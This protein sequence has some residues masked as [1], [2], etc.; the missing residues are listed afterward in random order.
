[1]AKT[2]SFCFADDLHTDAS[3][4]RHCGSWLIAAPPEQSAVDTLRKELRDEHTAYRGYLENLLA[5]LK[6]VAVIIVGLAVAVTGYFGWQ[7]ST[8]I[9]ASAARIEHD[10]QLQM[11]AAAKAATENAQLAMQE[12]LNSAETQAQIDAAIQQELAGLQTKVA[13]E[14]AASRTEFDATMAAVSALKASAQA[15]REAFA[16]ARGQTLADSPSLLPLQRVRAGDK[17]GL[18]RLEDMRAHRVEALTFVLGDFYEGP[19]IW[20]YFDTLLGTAHF[21]HVVL[22]EPDGRVFGLVEA[23]ALATQ[24]NPPEQ[25]LL[26]AE[27]GADP[28]GQPDEAAV[29]GWNAFATDLTNG[30][31]ERLVSLPMFVSGDDA[32]PLDASSVAALETM[33]VLAVDRL[34]VV[35][36]DRRFA[37]IVER[38]RLTTRVL[39]EIAPTGT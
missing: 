7:T 24:L 6:S 25:A 23:A 21:R 15:I 11:A 27:Y 8:N 17:E 12:R 22:L 31:R 18:D 30:N 9:A 5:Q 36:V 33:E 29:P 35:D 37:G 13:D 39:L 14:L 2:C 34:P 28:W 20:K 16:N 4:C 10:S 38:G 32:V 26:R 3:R 19:M 1:M